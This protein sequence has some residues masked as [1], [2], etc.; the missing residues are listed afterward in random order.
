MSKFEIGMVTG[1]KP[2]LM[3]TDIPFHRNPEF[4]K[5][6][7]EMMNDPSIMQ[8]FDKHAYNY[9]YNPDYFVNLRNP[10]SQL[11][12]NTKNINW[13]DINLTE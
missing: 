4:S 1:G 2:F 12:Y 7:K 9:G 5:A 8:F 10:N 13:E 11:K 3:K 6:F